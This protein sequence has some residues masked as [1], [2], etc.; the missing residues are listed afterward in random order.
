MN[1]QPMG[2]PQPKV[3]AW[4]WIVLIIVILAAGGFGAWYYLMGPGKKTTTTS[5]P[6]ATTTTTPSTSTTSTSTTPAVAPEKVA[7]NFYTFYLNLVN[8]NGQ[9]NSQARFVS[10]NKPYK[11]KS[12][13]SKYLTTDLITNLESLFNDQNLNYDPIICAQ[14][15][16]TEI[17]YSDSKISGSTATVEATEQFATPNK[18]DLALKNVGNEWKINTITCNL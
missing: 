1:Q 3:R 8:P 10:S 6:T 17:T 9:A 15:V 2:A 11:L 18:V 16:P 4:L 7:E 13:F 12:D 14:D 5:T